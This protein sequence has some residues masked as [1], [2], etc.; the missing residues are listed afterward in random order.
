MTIKVETTGNKIPGMY[1]HFLADPKDTHRC[2][3]C[4]EVVEDGDDV[5]MCEACGRFE[6]RKCVEPRMKAM[7]HSSLFMCHDEYRKCRGRYVKTTNPKYV[8]EPSAQE[9][10][11]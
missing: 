5:Y 3:Y 8:S 6:H 4:G 7:M 9:V 11:I 10:E 1:W 2:L